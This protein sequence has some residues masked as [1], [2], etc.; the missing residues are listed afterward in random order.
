MPTAIVVDDSPLG[1]AVRAELRLN[2]YT[3]VDAQT[4]RKQKQPLEGVIF[5]T[6]ASYKEPRK[7]LTSVEGFRDQWSRLVEGETRSSFELVVEVLPFLT[8]N[9]KRT[10]RPSSIVFMASRIV[11]S[12]NSPNQIVPSVV[13]RAVTTFAG[14]LFFEKRMEGIRVSSINPAPQ[15]K[16]EA[17]A[18]CLVFPLLQ[19]N[20]T[21]IESIDL[22]AL[23]PSPR[24]PTLNYGA[25]F[26]T[27]GS[28]GIGKG[29]ALRIARDFKMP[30]AIL[31]R[32]Q[33]E[34]DKVSAECAKY[35]GSDRVQT[36]AFDARDSAKL[37][38]AIDSVAAKYGGIS[39]L[40]CSA[41]INRRANA[42]SSDG[43]KVADPKV[44]QNLMDI[45]FSSAM[46][47]TQYALP[48]MINRPEGP[49]IFY[50][51]SRTIRVG[52]APG[53]QAYIA[54]KMAL[55]GYAASV[56]QEIKQFG[57]KVVT[58]NVGLVATDL[59]TKAPKQ[60]NFIPAPAETQIQTED[61]ADAVAF[62]LNLGPETS[63]MS[64]DI[65]GMIEEFQDKD[66]K[67]LKLSNL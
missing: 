60:N 24:P 7:A 22:V 29:I 33:A 50:V 2:G 35:V 40:V 32:D 47:A 25:C 67:S 54:S 14:S 39:V 42:V 41:G 45:N 13:K 12:P 55:N 49:A 48:Y 15:I 18:K 53:Q 51:G 66:G 52:N 11:R 30:M 61:V 38:D 20:T 16:N 46:F 57:V 28:R 19:S 63:P 64:F 23:K 65:C 5:C 10:S 62:T 21:C 4:W 3:A 58:L 6:E 9:W 26:V 27:G 44:W 34:L 8:E 1:D 37:K 36:F 59:G 43:K 31:G 56:Q 17:I